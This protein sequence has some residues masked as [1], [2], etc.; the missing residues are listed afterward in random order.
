MLKD[1][2]DQLYQRIKETFAS[3]ELLNDL[4]KGVE[5]NETSFR[6]NP[7]PSNADKLLR[8][9]EMMENNYGLTLTSVSQLIDTIDNMIKKSSSANDSITTSLPSPE[10]AKDMVKNFFMDKIKTRS[11]PMPNYSGCYAYKQK[12]PK[13]NSFVWS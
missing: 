2:N 13:P 6:S 11:P 4:I 10:S 7:L 12:Q 1:D 5:N 3:I 8:G 9:V